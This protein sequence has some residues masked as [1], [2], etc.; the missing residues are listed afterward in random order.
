MSKNPTTLIG[1]T[2]HLFPIEFDWNPVFKK[3]KAILF[4][5]LLFISCSHCSLLFSYWN[6]VIK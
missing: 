1:E 4:P 3:Q 2:I 5:F 6:P